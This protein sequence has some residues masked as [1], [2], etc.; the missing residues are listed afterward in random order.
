[1]A[2]YFK[3]ISEK[4]NSIYIYKS[5]KLHGRLEIIATKGNEM[6]TRGHIFLPIQM[7]FV[8]PSAAIKN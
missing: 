2:V 7:D 4:L 1:M 8:S 5:K 6:T 3:D